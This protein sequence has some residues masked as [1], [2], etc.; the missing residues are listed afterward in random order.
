MVFDALK[1]LFGGS[2]GPPKV[3][4]KK[5]FDIPGVKSG[6]GTMSAVYKAKDRQTGRTVCLKILDADKTAEFEARFKGLN[7][8][9]EGA[10]CVQP[11]HEYLTTTYEYGTTTDDEPFLVMEWVEGL[12]LQALVEANSPQIKGKR[13]EILAQV[14]DGL[15][16]MHE[17]KW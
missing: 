1:S 9:C 5:R 6:Q 11:R 14:A 15:A 12:G 7:K 8:P 3:D 4:I 2:K 10:I 13:N 17:H 16:Y